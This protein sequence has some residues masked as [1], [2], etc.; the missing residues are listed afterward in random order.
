MAGLPWVRL[1]SNIYAH[2][3]IL[4]LLADP[5]SKKWQALAA[6]MM[7]LAW[8]A[9]QGTD[10]VVPEYALRV[11]HASPAIARLLVKYQLWDESP[12]GWSIRNYADRQQLAGETYTVRKSQKEGGT[13]GNCIRWH[14]PD[15]GCWRSAQ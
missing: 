3:K 12:S 2:D 7:A 1:D 15:C 11:I 10:G 4:S 8:S 5:S 6:Y 14:G 9:G 13:K